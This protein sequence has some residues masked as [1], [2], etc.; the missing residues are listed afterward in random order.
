M[1]KKTIRDIN[2]V[3][4]KVLVR[5]DFNVPLD[6]EGKIVDDTRIIEALPTIRYLLEKEAKIILM[7]HLG[8]PKGKIVEKLR[9][10][11]VGRRLAELLNQHILILQDC[12]GDDIEKKVNEMEE[13]DIVLLENLRF[14]KEEEENNHEFARSL[15]RL[16]EIFVNDAFATSHRA[17]AS[18]ERITHFLPSVAGLLMEK[19]ILNLSKILKKPDR[20]FIFIVGGAKISTKIF[21]I[22]NLI[23]K[24]DKLLLGGALVNTILRAQGFGVGK[25][26]IENEMILE[27]KE[28][29]GYIKQG[30]LVLPQDFIVATEPTGEAVSRIVQI[31]DIKDDEMILDIGPKTISFYKNYIEKA[32]TIVWNGPMGM[33]EIMKFANGSYEIARVIAESKGQ[34]VI[35]GGETLE[36]VKNLGLKERIGFISTGGGAMLE[37]LAGK[38]LPAIA[39]LENK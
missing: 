30:K 38:K 5:V 6:K 12:V 25:S 23:E 29:L 17:H 33:F 24:V 28:L 32:K 34:T 13:G 36:I 19:E 14:H 20:P 4:K 18:T 27:A 39:V 31:A 10:E 8:R 37:F 3:R 9:L 2:V 16:A 7:S 15:A 21:V 1:L 22:R 26:L 11:P 35:G